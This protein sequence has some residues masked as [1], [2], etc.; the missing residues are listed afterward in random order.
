MPILE[1]LTNIKYTVK[2]SFNFATEIFDQNS[3]NFMGSL[4]ID[5]SFLK[6]TA[7]FMIEKKKKIKDLLSLATKE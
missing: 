2:D 1:P 3:S 4:D 6:T 7:L 5:T